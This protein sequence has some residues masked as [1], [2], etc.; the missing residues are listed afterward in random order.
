MLVKAQVGE[1]CAQPDSPSPVATKERQINLE[2]S[3]ADREDV[4]WGEVVGSEVI[5]CS[6]HAIIARA[7]LVVYS[8]IFFDLAGEDSIRVSLSQHTLSS[9]EWAVV[10]WWR[11]QAHAARREHY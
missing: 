6:G 9:L 5:S 3:E 1:S 7:V 4:V 2:E 10:N 8:L 11:E